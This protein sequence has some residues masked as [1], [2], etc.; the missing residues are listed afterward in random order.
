MKIIGIRPSSFTGEDKT[1]ISGRNIY[2]TYPLEK[3]E[4]HGSERIFVTDAKL[5]QWPYQPK[6][7]DEVNVERSMRPEALLDGHI[8]QG[9]VDQTARCTAREDADGSW[10]YTF[11]Y[12]P[13]GGGLTT[14][15]KGSVAVNGVSL[16][17][18]DPTP[19][20]FRVAI[21]PY[22]FEHTNFRRIDVGTVV[23]LE[24]DIVGKY[25]ARLME[26]YLNR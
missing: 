18:C 22:T 13:R 11:E 12:E 2:L 4:G 10:Y 3:G 9:H 21:I 1:Q 17:V 8:V 26:H 15:E 7:G 20:S 23:N 16:T 24:F 5:N 6:V 19:S 25:I 14:V